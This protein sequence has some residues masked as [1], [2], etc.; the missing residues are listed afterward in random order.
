M[1]IHPNICPRCGASIEKS[2]RSGL[3][4]CGGCG[5]IPGIT[6]VE[7]APQAEVFAFADLGDDADVGSPVHLPMQITYRGDL[8]TR[9]RGLY[10]DGVAAAARGAVAQALDHFQDA[11]GIEP[12]FVDAHM[13]IARLSPD[14]AVQREHLGA[15][16]AY[17][18]GNGEALRLWMLVRGELTP[19]GAARAARGETPE[20]RRADAPV[21]AQTTALLC[22]VCSG[23]M[24]VDDET[25][26]V[27]CRFCGH[28]APARERV[29]VGGRSL[30]AALIA[31]KAEPV[32][33][34]IGERLLHCDECGAER[35]IPA[36][37]LSMACPFCGSNQ[38]IER[39][40]VGSFV[41][42]DGVIPFAL[43][44]RAVVAA[45]KRALDA[46]LEKLAG[47]LDDNRVKSATID[48]IF[49]PFW[50][51]DVIVDIRRTVVDV[52]MDQ[53]GRFG[54]RPLQPRE[55]NFNDAIFNL[56][57]QGIKELDERLMARID[58]YEFGQVV[59]YEPGLLAK[60][61][62]S[63]YDVDFDAASLHARSQ[64]TE[65]MREKHDV[66]DSRS[67]GSVSVFAQ[68]QSM[69]FSLLLL[70][71]YVVTMK[72]RDGDR[73]A[74][75]VNGQTGAVAMGKTEKRMT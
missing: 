41:Q 12:E 60:Q 37:T 44:E 8:A 73:R 11:L 38:V 49:V 3:L 55:E 54:G 16:L 62:A 57:I 65:A 42:P 61:P 40:A 5:Y 46:P 1:S 36:T 33:W 63:L 75:L 50:V 53:V 58:R 24:T 43:D 29:E 31:R 66:P 69:S 21:A 13:A 28:V 45:I 51:F 9:A 35:T 48:P 2:A 34:L 7:T 22:P 56:P 19:E 6:Q 52:R 17:D 20:V 59:P 67:S 39:D 14:V 68:V 64:A 26:R 47:I 32:R 4:M 25:Q 74:A 71:V 70:P 27:T 10:Q 15:A 23:H 18:P 72:E 30:G